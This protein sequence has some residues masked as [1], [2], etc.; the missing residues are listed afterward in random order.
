MSVTR[1][2]GELTT[3]DNDFTFTL[4]IADPK[5]RVLYFEGSNDIANGVND[6]RW[7]FNEYMINAWKRAGDIEWDMFVVP[8]GRQYTQGRTVQF[9]R[10][11]EDHW[12]QLDPDRAM[13]AERADWFAY[14]VVICSDVLKDNFTPAQLDWVV[15]LVTGRGGGFCMIGGNTS[16]DTGKWHQ[17]VWEKIVPVDMLE[18]GFGHQWKHVRPVFPESAFAHP[19]MQLEADPARNRRAFAAHPEF[20]GF[21]DIR[22]AK[23][24]A[25]VLAVRE[26]TSAPLIAVQ[27]YGKGRSMAFLSDSTGGWGTEYENQWGPELLGLKERPRAEGDAPAEKP[28][29]YYN[30]FWVNTVRWLAEKSVRRQH[31]EVLGRSE[32]ISY[33]PGE[34]V[35]VAVTLPGVFDPAELPK[36]TVGARLA[37]EGEARVRLSYDRDRQEFVGQLK[38]PRTIKGSEVEVVF[39]SGN[40]GDEIRL[41]VIQQNL[42]LENPRPDAAFM[43]DLAQTGGGAVLGQ[44][45]EAHAFFQQHLRATRA[46]L[47]PYSEPLWSQAAVWAALLALFSAEWILRRLSAS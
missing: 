13:P 32:A 46:E 23:P 12:P 44:P 10:G 36:Q 3:A 37:L 11:F 9:V 30:R 21:H 22:R 19:I 27:T 16:F 8:K 33:R 39:D 6:E 15:E 7:N 17:T 18:F 4:E 35:K 42:E 25:T 5:I 45:G 38:L 20:E 34:V 41:R 2:D 1:L 40:A 31:R 43:A 29:Q 14:D 28:N 47:T 24:G 26:G